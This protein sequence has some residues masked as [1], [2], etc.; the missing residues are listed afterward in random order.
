MISAI[1]LGLMNAL[2]SILRADS[3]SH[4][5]TEQFRHFLPA[6]DINQTSR[7]GRNG[8]LLPARDVL[9]EKLGGL[10]GEGTL[11]DEEDFFSFLFD[12]SGDNAA[13]LQGEGN[14]AEFFVDDFGG[15]E[16]RFEQGAL[17]EAAS[18]L[19]KI[20]PH[21]AAFVADAVANDA[22]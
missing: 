14:V 13:V 9:F 15:F 20:R 17:V 4:Q 21:H 7:H 6:K 11:A 2:G 10:F 5:E 12:N 18:N 8:G 16:D 1:I 19:R 3:G 22:L